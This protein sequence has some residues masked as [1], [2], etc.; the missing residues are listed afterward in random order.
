MDDRLLDSHGCL[1][2]YTHKPLSESISVS[3]TACGGS[4]CV[5]VCVDRI[6]TLEDLE[7][8]K[9]KCHGNNEAKDRA[10]SGF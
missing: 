4:I 10:T 2:P 5:S 3:V 7:L 1:M 6:F 9:T 8:C